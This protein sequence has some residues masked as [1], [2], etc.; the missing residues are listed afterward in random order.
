L[1]S[2]I[3]EIDFLPASSRGA[4]VVIFNIPVSDKQEPIA[5]SNQTII[6]LKNQYLHVL[7]NLVIYHFEFNVLR[8]L[9]ELKTQNSE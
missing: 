1:Y 4:K 5:Q 2:G 7:V 8:L 3:F 9:N 6:N